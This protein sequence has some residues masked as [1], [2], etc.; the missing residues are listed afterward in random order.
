MGVQA[1]KVS[2]M[3]GETSGICCQP[4]VAVEHAGCTAM[5]TAAYPVRHQPASSV[6]RSSKP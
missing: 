4:L 3:L 5:M 6:M 1:E 2:P